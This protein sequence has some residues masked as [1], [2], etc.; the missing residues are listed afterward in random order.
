M[1]EKLAAPRQMHAKLTA[2]QDKYSEML[3]GVPEMLVKLTAMQDRMS[4]D[5]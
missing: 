2:M 1:L 3:D 4:R 5:D